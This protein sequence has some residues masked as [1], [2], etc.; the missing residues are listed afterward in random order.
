[1]DN[2]SRF[3][4][5]Q[6]EITLDKIPGSGLII[7]I[8]GGGEGLVSRI[9]GTRVCA[10]DIRMS[11]IR[12]AR[13]HN[14][15]ANW[16]ACDGQ[17]LCFNDCSFQIATLWF[18]LGYMSDWRIKE[19]VM[20]EVHRVLEKDGLV[21]IRA[22]KIDCDEERLVF[23]VIYTLPNGTLSQTGYGIK[24]NQNQ[25][26]ST[27]SKMLVDSNFEIVKQV[28]SSHWFQITARKV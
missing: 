14:P 10:V 22:S 26:F 27:I 1:M 3:E 2:L 25:T 8:G 23:R 18:S 21:S 13:I 19:N 20:K 9:E 24:G 6:Q 28:D 7:D 5:P 15:P 12:E 11:E 16:F 17:R 4:V